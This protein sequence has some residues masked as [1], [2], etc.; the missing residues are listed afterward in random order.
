MR[1]W[2][3]SFKDAMQAAS[4]AY[5]T[6]TPSSM[7]T[8]LDVETFEPGIS[9]SS[10]SIFGQAI[11][12]FGRRARIPFRLLLAGDEFFKTISMR[13]ELYVAANRRYQMSLRQG[14][15]ATKRRSTT[16]AWCCLIRVLCAKI[17]ISRRATTR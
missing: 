3:D 9:S 5:R 1:G 15:S 16:P 6:E 2:T 13:G 7:A 4:V 10:G 11:N 17:W 14:L 8:K 12:E